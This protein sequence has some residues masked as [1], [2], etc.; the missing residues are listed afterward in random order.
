M[1]GKRLVVKPHQEIRQ[2]PK[3]AQ[4]RDRRPWL[5]P[6]A[7]QED[8]RCGHRVLGWC[9]CTGQRTGE[10]LHVQPGAAHGAPLPSRELTADLAGLLLEES[11]RP[12][13]W[14]AGPGSALVTEDEPLR[15]DCWLGG[16]L[17]LGPPASCA[18][19]PRASLLPAQNGSWL[20]GITLQAV[21]GQV[22]SGGA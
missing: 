16:L 22:P 5:P 9:F 20:L 10:C 2:Y 1:Q 3:A 7:L 21:G 14:P 4:S 6:R 13:V 12:V 18:Q 15:D 17:L 11:T 19:A 8:Q